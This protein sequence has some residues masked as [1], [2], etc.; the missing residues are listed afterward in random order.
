MTDS[1]AYQGPLEPAGECR[2][3]IPKSYK[4]G[5]RVDGIIYADDRYDKAE[6]IREPEEM[7]AI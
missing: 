4:R 1:R 5:M 6:E 2:W 7:F 3:R